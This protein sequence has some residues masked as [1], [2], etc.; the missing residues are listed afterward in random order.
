MT[1]EQLLLTQESPSE[2]T[3]GFWQF[4]MQPGMFRDSSGN[5]QHMKLDM[6]TDDGKPSDGKSTAAKSE[7]PVKPSAWADYC[8]VLLNT[9]E[10]LYVD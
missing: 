5:G 2:R 10:F 8:H 1:R 9:S 3:A 4:E 7:T 6:T